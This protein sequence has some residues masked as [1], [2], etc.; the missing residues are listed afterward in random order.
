MRHLLELTLVTLLAGSSAWAAVTFKADFESGTAANVGTITYNAGYNV[1]VP[2]TSGPDATLGSYAL[3]ADPPT[4]GSAATEITLTPTAAAT[5][6]GGQSAVVSLDFLIRR[7]N[8]AI[9]SH[10]VTGYDSDDNIIFQFVL[11]ENNEFGNGGGDRQ[12][13]GYADSTGAYTFSGLIDSGVV[14]GSYWF[15]NDSS[16]AGLD[17]SKDAHFDITVTSSGWSVYNLKKDGSTFGQTTTLSTYDGG[18]FTELAYVKVTG[19][20]GSAGGYFDNLTIEGTA[21]LAATLTIATNSESG[22]FTVNGNFPEAVTGLEVSDFD[23]SNGAITSS[24]ITDSNDTFSIEVTPVSNGDVTV[25]LPAGTVTDLGG[26]TTNSDSNV[27]SVYYLAPGSDWPAVE[28]SAPSYAGGTFTVAVA[29][30]E[31]VTGLSASDFTV[32][33]G[34]AANL[35]GSGADYTVE[36]TPA[37]D[38]LEITADNDSYVRVSLPENAV[39]DLD[40]D[41][42]GNT[43]S[44]L[45]GVA[46]AVP[47]NPGRLPVRQPEQQSR[48]VHSV[49]DLFAGSFRV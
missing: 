21:G 31:A 37:L 5:L 22:A 1:Q 18:M 2:V 49:C 10:Y 16:P 15:G 17:G 27:I 46:Y 23:I 4:D 44:D 25:Q 48:R 47:E 9:K 40:G 43:A 34:S 28:L 36:I 45:L 12:R 7:T 42:L 32:V 41:N 30:D 24:S 3:Y 35:S 29:F 14:P 20:S 38:G 8:G 19:E 13:P 6:S 26:S 33:N 39:T 11:G